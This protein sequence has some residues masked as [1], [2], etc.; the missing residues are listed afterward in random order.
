MHPSRTYTHH[1]AIVNDVQYHPIHSSIIGSVSDDLTLQIIDTRRSETRRA[2]ACVKNQHTDAIN[3]IAFNPAEETLVATGSADKTIGL[4]DIRNL[5]RKLHS[6][7]NHTEA[8]TGLAWHPSDEA[9]LASSSY[10]RK[11]MFWDFTRAGEE[12]SAEDAEDGPPELY[13]L[14][15]H[16]PLRFVG[17]VRV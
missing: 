8:V 13:V 12:Q 4:F 5:S 1:N 6:L 11:L 15:L 7:Q 10:D 14:F 16:F 17:D 2:A 9:I 3:A